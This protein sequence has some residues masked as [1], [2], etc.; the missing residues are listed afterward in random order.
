LIKNI[1]KKELKMNKTSLNRKDFIKQVGAIGLTFVGAS[2]LLQAC[3]SDGEQ[4][5]SVAP[6]PCKSTSGLT[7]ADLAMRKNLNYIEQ[8]EIPDQRCDNC[9][10]YKDPEAGAACGGCLLFAGPV[11]AAGWCSS[12]VIKQA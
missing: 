6:D 2:T 4:A 10:L 5:Q 12:W 3:G 1:I 7:D 8:T 9:Q 11:T